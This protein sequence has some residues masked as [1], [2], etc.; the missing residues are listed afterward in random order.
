MS[1]FIPLAAWLHTFVWSVAGRIRRNDRGQATAEYALVLLGAA[2][3]AILVVTWATK[4]DRIGNL[5]DTVF[6]SVTGKIN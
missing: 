5:L 1:L 2:A 3:L 6:D 4:T